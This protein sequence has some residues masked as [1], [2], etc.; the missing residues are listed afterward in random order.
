MESKTERIAQLNDAFRK[1]LERQSH[2][3][4]TPGIQALSGEDQ[5]QI[6]S[7][8]KTFNDFSEGNDPYGEHN[9]GAIDYEGDRIFWK[10]NYYDRDM[11]YG[12]EDP[13]DPD[14]T[15]RVMTIMLAHEW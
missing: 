13:S 5:L 2:V 14:Q 12:S 7:L 11:K 6:F 15:L 4:I 1:T 10:I 8:V 3:Y 9:F